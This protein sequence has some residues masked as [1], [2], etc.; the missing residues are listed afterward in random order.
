MGVVSTNLKAIRKV[1]IDKLKNK[2]DESKIKL[3]PQEEEF[4]KEIV[5]PLP[6]FVRNYL[7]EEGIVRDLILHGTV[8][9]K[10]YYYDGR[11]S[12]AEKV[13]SVFRSLKK[14]WKDSV[15]ITFESS[16]LNIKIEF[17]VL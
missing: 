1:R 6:P 15:N 10:I 14:K 16:P 9:R 5:K 11:F 7:E 2:K 13:R 12:S 17:T 3:D 8:K 4:A